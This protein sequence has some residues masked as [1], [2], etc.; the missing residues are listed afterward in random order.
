MSGAKDILIKV[1]KKTDADKVVKL[2]HYSGKVCSGSQVNFGIFH[3]ERIIG[4]MQFGPS[5][6]KRRTAPGLLVGMNEY[7]E[8]NRMAV[9][10]VGIKNIESRAI[11]V[12]L[13]ILKK[14][15]PFLKCILT[16]ADACQCGDG[17]IYRA[18][19]F[20]LLA[21]NKNKSLLTDGKT[22]IADKS[23]NNVKDKNGVGLSSV[24]KKNGFKPLIGFQF[25]YVYYFDKSLEEKQKFIPF[26]KIPS[27]VKMYLG[28]RVGSKAIVASGFQSEEG[29]ET[30]TPALHL[31]ED[32]NG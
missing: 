15:Y 5:I 22:I 10:D 20:K 6:D 25:K 29:G 8:L 3:K 18:S 26:D 12:G 11:S 28:K 27:E 32:K 2:H 30:P 1:I 31:S 16:Y 14:E 24:Y 23:L 21:I 7:L 19:G 4:A 9:A 13:R 17:T